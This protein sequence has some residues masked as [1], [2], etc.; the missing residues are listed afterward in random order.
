MADLH[1]HADGLGDAAAVGHA[2]VDGR[3]AVHHVLAVGDGFLDA[4]FTIV[5]QIVAGIAVDGGGQQVGM[6]FFFQELHQLD[7]LFDQRHAGAGLDQGDFIF[8]G[9]LQLFGEYFG[10]GQGLVVVHRFL[11]VDVLARGPGG[12]HFLLLAAE[13]VHWHLM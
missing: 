7:V 2:V 10:I 9:L 13:F 4:L 3:E 1:G 11:E 8:A 5:I 12:Q 6:A